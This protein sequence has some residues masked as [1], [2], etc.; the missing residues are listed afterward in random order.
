MFIYEYNMQHSNCN[1]IIV[2]FNYS[3]IGPLICFDMT[4][5]T[6][7]VKLSYSIYTS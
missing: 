6:K 2:T 4:D 5:S 3:N 1:C 7:N